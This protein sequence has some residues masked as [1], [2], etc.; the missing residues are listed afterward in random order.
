DLF[1]RTLSMNVAQLEP[2]VRHLRGLVEA[3]ATRELSDAQLLEQFATGR[4]EAAFFALMHRHGGVGWDVWRHVP[5]QEQDAEDAFQ[6]SFLV[7]A[8]KAASLRRGRGLGN[9]LYGVAYR[10]AMNAR[11]KAMRRRAH[12]SRKAAATL[13]ALP[14]AEALHELQT[15]LHEEIN[16]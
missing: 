11:R 5:R 1:R 12:E 6:A 3:Q 9:W 13:R 8:L 16:R 10:V 4:D 2:L 15:M 7:L 14:A